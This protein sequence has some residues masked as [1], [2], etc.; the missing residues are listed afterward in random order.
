MKRAF[1]VTTATVAGLAGVLAFHT[2]PANLSLTGLTS[3]TTPG[4]GSTTTS[5]PATPTTRSRS[6]TTTSGSTTTPNQ[7][8]TTTTT[9]TRRLS[10]A[11]TTTTIA[12]TTTAPTTTVASGTRSATGEL[13]NYNFGVLSVKVTVSGTK[14]T[15][16]TIA[17]LLVGGNYRSQ[18]I[19]QASIPVLESEAMSAQ[20]GTI[21]SVSGASYTSAGFQMSL[22][23]ALSKLGL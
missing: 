5:S 4:A 17:S 6:T 1:I 8:A 14:I 18:S 13:V 12:P 23:S 22:Q 7:R 2:Q 9:T 20:S 21:Q 15:D 19:D 10:G 3:G 16:V 11:T